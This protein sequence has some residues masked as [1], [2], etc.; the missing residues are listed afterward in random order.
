[1]DEQ[2]NNRNQDKRNDDYDNGTI[3]DR[4]IP[5]NENHEETEHDAKQE[6]DYRNVEDGSSVDRREPRYNNHDERNNES[7]DSRDNRQEHTR[8]DDRRE[9]RNGN[10]QDDRY[11]DRREPRYENHEDRRYHDNRQPRYDY[12]DDARPTNRV[13]EMV[14]GIMGSVFGI[15]AGIFGLLLGGISS[16]LGEAD[17]G[18]I[19]GQAI[20][21]IFVC[22]VTIVISCIINKNRIAMG[23]ILII[24]GLLNFILMGG[25]GILSGILILVAGVIALIRK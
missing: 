13:A 5:K 16:S 14:L 6:S 18:S 2:R 4:Q 12:R 17:G 20:G 22:I 19:F 15:I 8:H 25:F 1:M 3:V 23:V 9:S 10:Y 7:Y 11:T 24:G 21:V